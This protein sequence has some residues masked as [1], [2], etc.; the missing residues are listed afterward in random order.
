VR[1]QDAAVTESPGPIVD[2]SREHLGTS[3][4]AVI[5]LRKRLIDGA[6][7]LAEGRP[8]AAAATPGLYRIRAGSAVIARDVGYGDSPDIRQSMQVA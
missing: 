2:R 3:D 5:Q 6:R 7:A 1:D 4:T 8:P